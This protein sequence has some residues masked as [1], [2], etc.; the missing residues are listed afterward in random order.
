MK[1]ISV[2]VPAYNEAAN[3]PRLI[4]ELNRVADSHTPFAPA[5]DRDAAPCSL[6]PSDFEWEYVIVN[7][8]SLDNTLDVLLRLRHECPKINIVNLSRNFGKE[9]AMLAGMDYVTGDATV[10]MDA[11][12]QHPVGVIPEMIYWWLQGYD[13]VYGLRRTRGRESWLRKRLSLAFYSMLQGTTRIEVLPNVGDFRL[14]DRR[15]IDAV[16]K[17]PETQRYTKG[18]YC[19]VGYNKKGVYF[20]Q[21]NREKGRTSFSLRGLINLAIE[22]VTCFTTTPLR[23]ASILGFIVSFV[24]L[25]YLVFILFKTIF[26]GESVRGFP[27]LMCA[28]LFLGGVQLIAIGII[29]EYI[30]RIFNETKHRPV[31]IVE[32]YNGEKK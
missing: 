29:G 17:L 16:R 23:M 11:D 15:V 5:D 31:Y 25:I 6:C 27:T 28:I 9:N 13:D 21:G 26:W 1:K 22:G 7:D 20:E 19:W 10:I 4:E 12:L 30:G 2:L 14:L 24:A 8:G 3:L 32:S 18:L